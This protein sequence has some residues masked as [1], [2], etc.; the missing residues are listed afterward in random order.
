MS[1]EKQNDLLNELGELPKPEM[2]RQVQ[3]QMLIDIHSFSAKHQKRKRWEDNMKKVYV[4]VAS[5][6]AVAAV[7]AVSVITYN[8]AIVE[9]SSISKKSDSSIKQETP[10]I[11]EPKQNLSLDPIDL[12]LP[13]HQVALGDIYFGIP[14]KKDSV[15][16]DRRVEGEYTLVDIRDKQTNELLYRYG[17]TLE[18]TKEKM[19]FR[20]VFVKKMNTSIRLQVFVEIDKTNGTITKINSSNINYKTEPFRVEGEFIIAYSRS[21]KFPAEKVAVLGRTQISKKNN[22]QDPEKMIESEFI[23]EGF[24]IGVIK[25]N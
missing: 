5:S 13:E 6:L 4:S 24:Q 20:E 23:K 21:D 22:T 10:I 3:D 12:K 15:I 19:V 8:Q 1:N 11:E 14:F 16:I 18:D 2:P 25:K 17:E 7:I 9:D